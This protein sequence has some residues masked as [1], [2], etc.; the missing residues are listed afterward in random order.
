ME[1]PSSF[2]AGAISGSA[3][4]RVGAGALL[5]SWPVTES[6]ADS[7]PSAPSRPRSQAITP[8]PANRSPAGAA[9]TATGTPIECSAQLF[10]F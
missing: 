7:T 1:D 9:G 6:E 10:T 5:K 8:S 4:L 3:R 2:V